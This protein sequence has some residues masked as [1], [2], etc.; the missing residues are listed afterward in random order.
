M[1]KLSLLQ[2][3][4][5]DSHRIVFFGGAGVSTE[6]N[7]PDFRSSDGIYQEKYAYPPEQV[8]SH[9]FFQ[10]KPELFY[11]FYKEKM[12][13]LDAK[14]NKAHLKLAEM[15]AKGKLSAVITQNIDGLHQLAGSKNVLELHGS[16][17]RNYCQRC[18]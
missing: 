7:I 3:M 1:E 17:H 12:M 4:I 11:E 13:F 10:K 9:T 5:D 15:E 8:V 16:I 2:K 6:S 14:P 18:G